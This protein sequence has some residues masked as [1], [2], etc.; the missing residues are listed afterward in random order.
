MC[1]LE[2][3]GRI[4]SLRENRRIREIT[5][6]IIGTQASYTFDTIEGQSRAIQDALHLGRI[7]SSSDSTTL[8]FGESGTGKE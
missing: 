3:G 1:S 8:I 4:V 5:R 6:C 2:Q 7:A